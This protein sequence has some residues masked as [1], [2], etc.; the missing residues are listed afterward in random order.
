MANETS[1][2]FAGIESLHIGRRDST[3]AFTGFANLTSSNTNTSS[4]M[5]RLKFV[6]SVPTANRSAVIVASK[7]DNGE[8]RKF[9]FQGPSPEVEIRMGRADIVAAMQMMGATYYDLGNWRIAISGS[10]PA[11]YPRHDGADH[12]GRGR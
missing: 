7:G 6:Q 9:R 1:M 3:G 5:R 11:D 10:S 2:S 8:G 12:C 4:G